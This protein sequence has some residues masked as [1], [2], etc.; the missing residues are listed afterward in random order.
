MNQDTAKNLRT[1]RDMC[2]TRLNHSMMDEYMKLVSVGKV[3]EASH[4]ASKYD[5][6][7]LKLY[8]QLFYFATHGYEV[9]APTDGTTTIDAGMSV[10]G[11][12]GCIIFRDNELTAHT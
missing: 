12:Y 8:K 3:I 10:A 1:L 9:A 4:V 6:H 11:M 2:E 5:D 7:T